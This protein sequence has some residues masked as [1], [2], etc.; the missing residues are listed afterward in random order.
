MSVSLQHVLGYMHIST[1]QHMKQK[2]NSS[3]TS[4]YIFMD[5]VFLFFNNGSLRRN[6]SSNT[7]LQIKS[8]HLPCKQ[9]SSTNCNVAHVCPTIFLYRHKEQ[10]SSSIRQ[11]PSPDNIHTNPTNPFTTSSPSSHPQFFV[12]SF[13]NHTLSPPFP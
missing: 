7:Y 11:T 12:S 13:Y 5:C 6:L 2:P 1:Q 9:L 4:I 10:T 8:Q 3:R